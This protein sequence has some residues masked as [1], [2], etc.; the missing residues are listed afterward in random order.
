MNGYLAARN[1]PPMRV[2]LLGIA[3]V[4]GLLAGY[5]VAKIAGEYEMPH[6]AVAALLQAALLLR[7]FAA[8][9]AGTARP[10]WLRV[11]LVSV[12]VSAM[13]LGGAVRARA[14]KLTPSKEVG[15]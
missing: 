13:L 10:V 1:R 15:P 12:T 8:E 3:A 7:D 4:S 9:D 6:V 2:A 14:A 11:G 5:V